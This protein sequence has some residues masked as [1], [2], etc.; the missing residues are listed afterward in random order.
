MTTSG[1]RGLEDDQCDEK[2]I[3]RAYGARFHPTFHPLRMDLCKKGPY[4][5]ELFFSEWSEGFEG[6]AISILYQ[7]VDDGAGTLFGS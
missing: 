4:H 1:C 2:G 5:V 7:L 3:P 6:I